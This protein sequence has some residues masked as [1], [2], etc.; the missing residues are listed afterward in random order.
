MAYVIYGTR[1]KIKIDKSLGVQICPN[2]GHNVE[3]S[4]AH[5]SGYHHVYYIPVFPYIG[6]KIKAC[7]NC[8]IAEKLTKEEFNTIKKAE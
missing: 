6:W 1:R 8:G 2:C 3:M 4:L 5:E 7:P